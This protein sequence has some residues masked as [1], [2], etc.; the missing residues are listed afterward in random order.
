MHS[1]VDVPLGGPP[2]STWRPTD[3]TNL[4][5]VRCK[6]D[7]LAHQPIHTL[8]VYALS[9]YDPST[10]DGAHSSSNF[11]THLH[12]YPHLC[13]SWLSGGPREQRIRSLTSGYWPG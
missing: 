13:C 1:L 11:I 4:S 6:T 10:P 12:T 8:S 3:F 9:F 7:G 5:Q 2:G